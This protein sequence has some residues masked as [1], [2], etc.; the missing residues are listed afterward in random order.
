MSQLIRAVA[1]SSTVAATGRSVT[2]DAFE[3]GAEAAS[4]A[5]AALPIAATFCLVFGTTGYEQ[6]RLLAGVRSVI[7]STG[8][9][10]CSGEGVIVGDDSDERDRVVTV[11]AISSTS[12]RFE[13]E[14]RDDYAHDPAH[15]GR[16]LAYQLRAGTDLVGVILMTDGLTGDCGAFLAALQGALPKGTVVV[17]GCA[18]DDMTFSTTYQYAGE[19]VLSGGVCAVAVRGQAEMQVAVSHGCIPFGRELTASSASDGWLREIDGRPAW[20]VFKEYLDTDTDDLTAEGIVHL[21]FGEPLTPHQSLAPE[22]FIIHTPTRLDPGTGALFFPGGGFTSGDRIRLTRRDPEQIRRSAEVS[23]QQLVPI[24]GRVPAFVLQFDCAG[25]GRILFGI[26]TSE[27]IVKPLQLVLGISIPWIGLHTY[28]EIAA[29]G[30]QLRYHNYT[31]A[32]CAI[33]EKLS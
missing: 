20:Q 29:V 11:L 8:L 9:A 28:G 13:V 33:Y 31:V 5:C 24:D 16:E 7:G 26:C 19:R 2:L 30:S 10:G 12:I 1:S 17:G 23:A 22:S 32:L 25:R 4:A 14:C 15:C 6:D 21:G 3:A 27:E 18:G